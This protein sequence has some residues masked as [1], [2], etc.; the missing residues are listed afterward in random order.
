MDHMAKM[1]QMRMQKAN[2]KKAKNK[3]I[4]NCL[5]EA[6]KAGKAQGLGLPKK[7]C[8]FLFKGKAEHFPSKVKKAEVVRSPLKK[9]RTTR[10]FQKCGY[11]SKGEGYVRQSDGYNPYDRYAIQNVGILET[12]INTCIGHIRDCGCSGKLNFI[13]PED[14]DVQ[15]AFRNTLFCVHTVECSECGVRLQLESDMFEAKPKNSELNTCYSRLSQVAGMASKNMS[16]IFNEMHMLFSCLGVCFFSA[17]KFQ[18]LRDY[19]GAEIIKLTEE[20]V[21]GNLEREIE[22]VKNGKGLPQGLVV[23]RNIAYTL[24]QINSMRSDQLNLCLKK[25]DFPHSVKRRSD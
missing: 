8:N 13:Y 18:T 9:S 3:A 4:G 12:F 16:W 25:L 2:L 10:N 20:V 14:S 15:A 24:E 19:Q 22:M 6:K 23:P 5:T 21:A 7:V 1:L 11:N 17:S